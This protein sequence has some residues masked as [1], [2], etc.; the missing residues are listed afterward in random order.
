[1]C[2]C[3]CVWEYVRVCVC[4]CVSLFCN[5]LATLKALI[6]R[7]KRW[8]PV[9]FYSFVQTLCPY[10]ERFKFLSENIYGTYNCLCVRY[11]FILGSL[12][13]FFCCLEIK[14]WSKSKQMSCKQCL[15]WRGFLYH[16]SLR[17]AWLVSNQI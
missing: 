1:M 10:R 7:R 16:R 2:E 11:P 3:V 8:G 12:N 13:A 9:F 4:Y 6:D 17:T 14:F 15:Y 5:Y